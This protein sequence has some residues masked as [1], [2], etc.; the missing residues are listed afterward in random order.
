MIMVWSLW[1]DINVWYNKQVLSKNKALISATL[2]I[3]L[4]VTTQ[5]DIF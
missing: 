2:T 3:N 4:L 5:C 1:R